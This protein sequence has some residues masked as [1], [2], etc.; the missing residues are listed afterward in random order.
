MLIKPAADIPASEITPQAAY[1]RR[2]EFLAGA[3]ALGLGSLVP[4]A[5][6]AAPL[7]ADKSPLSSS[8][9]AQTPLKDIISYNNFYEFGVDK[10]DP[11]QAC[12]H[13][14]DQALEGEG[15]RPGR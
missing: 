4:R 3:A 8:G 7:Q 14:E 15:R 6:R 10:D 11:R 9:E 12:P 13:L 2:R 5:A 1:V